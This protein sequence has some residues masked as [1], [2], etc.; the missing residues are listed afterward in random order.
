M[1]ELPEVETTRRGIAPHVTG[2][3]ILAIRVRDAR[4]RWPVS[5]PAEL[6]GQQ[7]TAV[8]RRAKYLC[9]VLPTGGILIHLGM[10]GHLRLVAATSTP[11]RHAHVDIC[12]DDGRALRLTDPRRF[13]SVHYQPGDW[14]CH[15][16]LAHLGPE[17]LEAGFTGAYLFSR[18]RRR[19]APLKTFVM[20]ARIVV[21]VGN[22]YANEALFR[23]G[24]RPRPAAGRIT[25]A[26]AARLVAS[27]KETLTEAVAAGGTTLRDFVGGDGS[28]GYFRTQLAVYGREGLP[29]PR[30]RTR[31]KGLRLGNRATVYCPKCQ[32]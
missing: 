17:P 23:A 16:L 1:P 27:I 6:A 13:G 15:P 12:L 21:G 7:V 18:A 20:D 4:L 25:A 24:L 32:R 2:R 9:L 5:L 3:R 10:S 11:G 14:R 8:V 19:R 30:C 22:I 29:C 31:L 28:A 26:D